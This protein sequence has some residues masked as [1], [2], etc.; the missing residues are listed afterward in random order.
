MAAIRLSYYEGGDNFLVQL[1]PR[2]KLLYILWVFAL[3]IVFFHPLYQSI[4]LVSLLA[5]ILL[6]GISLWSV[7]KAG[8]FGVYVGIASFVLWVIFK[9]GDGNALFNIWRLQVTDLGI[10]IGLAVA[11]RIVAVLFA[12][13]VMAMTTPTRDII[14]GL[15]YLRVPMVF[16]MTVGFV[17]RL[18]PQLQ[19]EHATI[20]EAQKSRATEF[21]K[22]GLFARFRKHSTYIIP[23]VLRSL[24]IVSDISIAMEARAF[25]AY[26]KRT[27]AR[28]LEY[29]KVDKVILSVM[30]IIFVSAI[31]MRIAGLGGIEGIVGFGQ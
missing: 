17:L 15:Y 21:D 23:L 2:T 11:I 31:V 14:T 10:M 4:T 16:A 29:S 27:F 9:S 24:K 5:A 13:L 12:F 28:H 19:S 7:I 3:I 20:I 26:T 6:A 18:I 8:R 25:D 1:D 30:A 22:G